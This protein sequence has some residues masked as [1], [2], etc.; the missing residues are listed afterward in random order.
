MRERE[1]QREGVLGPFVLVAMAPSF[2]SAVSSLLCAEDNIFDD[3]DFGSEQITW[4]H[5]RNRRNHNQNRGFGDDEEDGLPLQ[6]SDEYLASIV[7]NE[8]HHLPR[9]DYLKRLL[10]GDLDLGARNEAV[11]WIRKVGFS[12]LAFYLFGWLLNHA[13]EHS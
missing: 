1:R 11:D 12:F 9:L 10:S 6:S 4:N 2:D 3:N 7:E 5:H 13:Y 8:S